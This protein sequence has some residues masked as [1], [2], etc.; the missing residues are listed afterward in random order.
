MSPLSKKVAN[1][2]WRGGINNGGAIPRSCSL[3]NL[4]CPSNSLSSLPP[5]HNY[6]PQPPSSPSFPPRPP[7]QTVLLLKAAA[8]LQYLWSTACA[9]V[10]R[11]SSVLVSMT[12]VFYTTVHPPQ[13]RARFD[14]S[15]NLVMAEQLGEAQCHLRSHHWRQQYEN[16]QGNILIF[17]LCYNNVT[18]EC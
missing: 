9:P 12:K 14:H 8:Q 1:K 11:L 18:I 6:T 13:L 17:N 5:A 10:M 4:I 7:R 16:G 3:H 2:E 15:T